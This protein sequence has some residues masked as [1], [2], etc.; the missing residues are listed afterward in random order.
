MRTG[1]AYVLG[2]GS[3]GDGRRVRVVIDLRSWRLPV[4]VI[5]LVALAVRVG[6]A[7]LALIDGALAGLDP[8][9]YLAS[10]GVGPG[11]VV[12]AIALAALC[13]WSAADDVPGARVV[14]GIGAALVA[15][16]VLSTAAAAVASF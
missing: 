12:V 14:A 13:W 2:P 5:L 3:R 11:E 16:Q 10:G 4:A 6:A 1:R 9:L 8:L 15:V 7:L